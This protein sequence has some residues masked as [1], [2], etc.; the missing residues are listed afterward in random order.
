MRAA[1]LAWI[2]IALILILPSIAA[3]GQ[4]TAVI[5]KDVEKTAAEDP[6]GEEGFNTYVHPFGELRATV[7]TPFGLSIGL[8]TAFYTGVLFEDCTTCGNPEAGYMLKIYSKHQDPT[9]GDLFDKPIL[10]TQGFDPAY[11]TADQFNFAEFERLLTNVNN[12]ITGEFV[13]R[14]GLLRVLYDRG[15]DIALLLWKNPLIAIETNALVTLQALRWLEDHTAQ[16]PGTEPVIIGPSMGG[17]VT[18]YAL[19][20]AGGD[21]PASGIRAR[22]FIA[23]DSPNRGAEVPMSLQAL[24]SYFSGES[25]EIGQRLKNL[26]SPAARQLLLSSVVLDSDLML[27]PGFHA[28]RISQVILDYEDPNDPRNPTARNHAEF[29]GEI[30]EPGFRA[31][32]KNIVHPSAGREEPIYMAALINGSGT[33]V[34]LNYPAGFTYAHQ[35]GG[36]LDILDLDLR[37]ADPGNLFQVFHGDKAS[38]PG[39]FLD[40]DFNEPVFMESV[41]G[42]LR[43]TYRTLINQVACSNA[44][45]GTVDFEWSFVDPRFGNPNCKKTN[46]LDPHIGNHPFIPS[47]SGV[48]L[49]DVSSI[50]IP[51]PWFFPVAPFGSPV[52]CAGATQVCM[53][54]EFRAPLLN[55]DHVSVTRENMRWFVELIEDRGPRDL[56]LGVDLVSKQSC[57]FSNF[58]SA[59]VVRVVV[60]VQ[61]Q[62]DADAPSS[63]TKVD[64]VTNPNGST[65]S[66]S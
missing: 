42:G 54:D 51:Q 49:L 19:Q 26:T 25:E 62:G 47:L 34:S 44:L 3:W 59:G 21:F 50:N 9:K 37:T 61:N 16:R 10:V 65:T 31:Q 40:Y 41:P 66:V 6:S 11:L 22:L 4:V 33:G 17:L 28:T 36:I 1:T 24:A 60:T 7:P 45:K 57:D 35:G 13:T 43:N 64:F 39:G 63:T 38:G 23:F 15:Y 52:K 56:G 29:M 2:T 55:Q 46:E 58:S 48:G 12:E 18:R 8:Q 20:L 53:F 14:L 27:R 30:N 32:I 5:T